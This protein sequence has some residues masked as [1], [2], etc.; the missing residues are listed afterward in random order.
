MAVVLPKGLGE[1][2]NVLGRPGPA[3]T[4]VQFLADVSD[5]IAPQVVQGLL[6]KVSF[7]AAPET[8]ATEGLAMFEKYGGPLTPE[9]RASVDQ[10]LDVDAAGTARRA[11]RGSN[12]GAGVRVADRYSST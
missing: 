10:W 7:T 9:Q 6:Q 4:E 2:R 12:A 8:M 11:R 1:G 3:R 5:P